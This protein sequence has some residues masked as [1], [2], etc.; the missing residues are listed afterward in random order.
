MPNGTAYNPYYNSPYGSIPGMI[1]TL[2]AGSADVPHQPV[3]CDNSQFV[4][5][6]HPSPAMD[7][8]NGEQVEIVEVCFPSS[9][10][11]PAADIEHDWSHV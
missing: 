4:P 10:F 11:P 8:Q 9:E 7:P 1:P 2:N 5:V 6:C 3:G